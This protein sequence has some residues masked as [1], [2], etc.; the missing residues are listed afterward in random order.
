MGKNPGN[1]VMSSGTLAAI[2]LNLKKNS[3]KKIWKFERNL[4]QKS[5]CELFSFFSDPSRPD[6]SR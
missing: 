2:Q 4:G 6:P 5:Q 1:T 3:T